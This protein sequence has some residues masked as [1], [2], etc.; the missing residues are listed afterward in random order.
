MVVGVCVVAFI[1]LSICYTS[2]HPSINPLFLHQHI[3]PQDTTPHNQT[4]QQTISISTNFTKQPHHTTPH[5]TTSH[6]TT[7]HHTTPHH[8]T[9]HHTTP[10]HTTSHHTTPHH[11]TPHH[12]TSH[13]TTQDTQD[14]LNDG[15]R[16]VVGGVE[17][18]VVDGE[19][20]GGC[21]ATRHLPLCRQLSQLLLHVQALQ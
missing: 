10:H 5:H 8:T 14:T 20:G 4:T 19:E 2:I 9:P 6:H 16:D 12:T 13:H 11:T 7:S 3:T 15:G 1:Y 21:H 17:K 18:G